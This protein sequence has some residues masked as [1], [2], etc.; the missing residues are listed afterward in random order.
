MQQ[1]SNEPGI[2]R[3]KLYE[4]LKISGRSYGSIFTHVFHDIG[5]IMEK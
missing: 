4:V 5:I 3:K 1:G 2:E